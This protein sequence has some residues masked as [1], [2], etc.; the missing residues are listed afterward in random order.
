MKN[1]IEKRRHLRVPL[2][3]QVVLMTPKGPIKGKT[4]DISASGLAVILFIEKPEIGDTFDIALKS[5]DGKDMRVAC[6]RV[7][8]GKL[9]SNETV[10]DT[11][12]VEFTKISTN[13]SEI[14]ASLVEIYYLI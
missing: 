4:A 5:S 10:Y 7:W 1:G 2:A 14:L 8:L 13:D 12:G 3:L 6:K 11:I 9:I